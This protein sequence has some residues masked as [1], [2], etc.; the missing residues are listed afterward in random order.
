MRITRSPLR[1]AG[2]TLAA[3]AIAV[4][5][6][7]APALAAEFTDGGFEGPTVGGNGAYCADG[8]ALGNTLGAWTVTDGC[9][10]IHT[11]AQLESWEGTQHVDLASTDTDPEGTIS[12]TFDTVA[13]THYIVTFAYGNNPGCAV[14]NDETFT[15]TVDGQTSPTT[16][17]IT[18]PANTTDTA[19]WQTSGYF[20]QATGTSATVTFAQ[21]SPSDGCGALLDDVR[22]VLDPDL[23]LVDPRIAAGAATLALG[24]FA[25]YR[26]RRRPATDLV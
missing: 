22:V 4:V 18:V 26:I 7:A 20:F 17:T 3:S 11:N 8:T 21:T 10:G 6:F 13:G 16:D 24:G 1:F 19:E 12:Q 2:V 15:V 23:P 14:E 25:V 5:G 9:V